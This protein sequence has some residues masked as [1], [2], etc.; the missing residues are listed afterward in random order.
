MQQSNT[1]GLI[2]C[3]GEGQ[4]IGFPYPKELFPDLGKDSYYPIFMD[5]F[6]H[7]IKV[8]NEIVIVINDRRELLIKYLKN[9]CPEDINV[10][11]VL[12]KEAISLPHAILQSFP[13]IKDKNVLFGIP[14]TIIVDGE[15]FKKIYDILLNNNYDLVC[16]YFKTDTPEK[17]G[18]VEFG[19]SDLIQKFIDK[20]KNYTKSNWMWGILAWSPMFT[21]SLKID[22]RTQNY[23]LTNDTMNIFANRNKAFG[24]KFEKSSYYDLGT[25][26]E[27]IDFI[28]RE[29]K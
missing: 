7:M 21:A 2:P 1:I 6:N 12:Q 4:R 10:Y 28:K 3:A 26:N 24:I 16:G 19:N 13:L 29:V 27:T 17:F 11:F 15:C 22:F 14:D 5:V 18:M 8:T 23:N 25:R 20:P 9:N